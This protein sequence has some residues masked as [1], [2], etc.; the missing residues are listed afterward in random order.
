MLQPQDQSPNS[1]IDIL[2]AGY[3]ARCSQPEPKDENTKKKP[4]NSSQQCPVR[5]HPKSQRHLIHSH[6][7]STSKVG[8]FSVVSPPVKSYRQRVIRNIDK[9]SFALAGT[10]ELGQCALKMQ[11]TFIFPPESTAPLWEQEVCS[12]PC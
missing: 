5:R 10:F 8:L 4:W 9:L 2:N 3:S 1:S 6:H 12:K 7:L 11:S